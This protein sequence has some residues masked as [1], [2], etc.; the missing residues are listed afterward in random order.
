MKRDDIIVVLWL[1][2]IGALFGIICYIV[3]STIAKWILGSISVA[4]I[5]FTIYVVIDAIFHNKK[6]DRKRIS[7]IREVVKS[8][9][10]NR[11]WSKDDIEA[12]VRSVYILIR[13]KSA[14][15]AKRL[16]SDAFYQSIFESIA[17]L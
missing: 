12:I 17:W 3:K 1:A 9:A 4:I 2:A 6:Q 16:I 13:A 8:E 10:K 5:C 11:Y 15:D 14:R 7:A